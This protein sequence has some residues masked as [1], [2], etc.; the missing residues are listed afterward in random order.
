MT[1]SRKVMTAS[2]PLAVWLVLAVPGS[3]QT[4]P[5][6][7]RPGARSAA[8]FACL[9]VLFERNDGQFDAAVSFVVR[10]RQKTAF[11]TP[12]GITFKIHGAKKSS[13]LKLDFVGARARKPV[14]H[15]RQA[16]VISS[17]RGRDQD[18]WVRGAATFAE[19]RYCALWPGI[20]LVCRADRI[21]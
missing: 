4:S 20:D 3:T 19:I 9:P 1:R 11:F 8:A 16:A 2:I 12:E 6:G 21:G 18:G 15:R 10:G 7:P 17:F 5:R 14:G 13:T